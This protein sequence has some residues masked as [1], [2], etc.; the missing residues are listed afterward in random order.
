[1][2]KSFALAILLG[3]ISLGGLRA[4][5]GWQTDYSQAKEAAQAQGKPMLLDFTGSDWCGW[6][7]KFDK[8]VFSTPQFQSYAQANLILV[9][10]DF[11][12]QTPQPDAEK[13]QNK[14]LQKKYGVEGYPTLLLLSSDEK[15]LFRQGGYT[16]GG[17]QPF[18]EKLQKAAPPAPVAPAP[19]EDIFTPKAN[20]DFK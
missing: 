11:P 2:V 5:D 10:V 7:M 18:L 6:C 14:G 20:P 13:S 15:E 19:P 17:P 16:D 12:Q 1:M 9:K 4:D 8:E 3:L